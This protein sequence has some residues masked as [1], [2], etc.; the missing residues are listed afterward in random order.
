MDHNPTVWVLKT[1]FGAVTYG[2]CKSGVGG[3]GGG[4]W[5]D[6]GLTI[7]AA[8]L[9]C[10][11]RPGPVCELVHSGGGSNVL[12]SHGDSVDTFGCNVEMC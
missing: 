8:R 1:Q 3:G 11:C 4:E 10:Y 12:H 6:I 2:T 7:S 5:L 9:R